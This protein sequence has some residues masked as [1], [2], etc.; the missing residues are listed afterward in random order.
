MDNLSQGLDL[1]EVPR[2]WGAL[3]EP[4]AGG[5]GEV[6]V[7]MGTHCYSLTDSRAGA[8]WMGQKDRF[9]GYLYHC[10]DPRGIH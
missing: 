9:M 6:G 7:Q 1:G 5:R 8:C 2:H 10:E 4:L 3:Q